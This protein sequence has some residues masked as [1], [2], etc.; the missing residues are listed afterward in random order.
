MLKK[1]VLY[2]LHVIARKGVN[3]KTY[4]DPQLKK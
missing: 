3:I 1:R 2:V 4:N